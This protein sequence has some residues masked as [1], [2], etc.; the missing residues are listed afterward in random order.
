MA[1]RS[2]AFGWPQRPRGVLAALVVAVAVANVVQ[3]Q[4]AR[5]HVLF[6]VVDDLGFDDVFFRSQQIRTPTIDRLASEGLVLNQVYMQDVCS[7]SRSVLPL[8]G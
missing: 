8:A 2:V 3:A 4:N 7:P 5:P 1:A 6:I